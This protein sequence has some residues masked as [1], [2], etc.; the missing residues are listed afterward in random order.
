MICIILSIRKKKQIKNLILM[1]LLKL[2]SQD[3]EFY[4][5][6][7]INPKTNKLQQAIW[8]FPEQKINYYQFNNVVIFNNTYKTNRFEMLFDIFTKVNN[9]GQSVCFTDTIIQY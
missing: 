4:Y 9:H 8:M 3:S 6:I 1:I 2:K 7:L 5:E